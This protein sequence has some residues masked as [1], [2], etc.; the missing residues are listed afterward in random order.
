M[1]EGRWGTA[2]KPSA[3]CS[4]RI[5]RPN[6]QWGSKN[7]GGS[8]Q[9]TWKILIRNRDF[10]GIVDSGCSRS[11][12]GN[13]EK[14]DDFVKIVGGTVTFGGG[15]GKITRKGTIRTSKLNFENV[16]YVEELQNFNFSDYVE[17]LARLQKQA[18]EAN[19]TADT[20]LVKLIH[21]NLVG[22][23]PA[24][25]Q[26]E[27][28]QF[29]NQEVW[30]L[31]PLPDGK[32][33]IGTKWILKNKRDA[34]GIVI[35][36]K[37]RLV[38]QGHRQEEGIDYDE[39]FA[40]VARIEAIRLFLAFASYRDLCYSPMGCLEFL[41]IVTACMRS[42][43]A[44][45]GLVTP[46]TSH[47]EM[48]SKKIFKYLKGPPNYGLWSQEFSLLYWKAYS[49]IE[50]CWISWST[51]A[52]PTGYLPQEVLRPDKQ[53]ALKE[54]F[55]MTES[56][57][58]EEEEQDVDPLIKLAKAAA[59]AADDSAVP[60]GGSNEDDIPPSSSTPSEACRCDQLSSWLS[61]RGPTMPL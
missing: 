58:E 32:I 22:I 45:K 46:F 9:S 50:L 53:T 17:E 29:V 21:A 10:M 2:V 3:G 39:V 43:Q 19:A 31:V 18:Y 20:A 25:K 56:D 57:I 54:K 59:T 47:P 7:N 34:R 30:K 60:T 5:Q 1:D 55:V 16:Y 14:L 42:S 44:T 51:K 28:Q 15:D 37:A 12:T 11:M 23:V 13:K 38:A 48:Q 27:M 4:W 41:S 26:E 61:L 8:H 33:A 52:P 36:N 35:R 49:D 40:P 6:M 24:S